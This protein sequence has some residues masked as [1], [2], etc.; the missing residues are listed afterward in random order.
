MKR[1]IFL[2]L[3]FSFLSFGQAQTYVQ[4]ILDASGSMWNKL[5]DDRYRI[6]ACLL[7]TSPSPRDA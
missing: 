7:Y 5:T 1:S 3:V 2:V 4:L 6:V